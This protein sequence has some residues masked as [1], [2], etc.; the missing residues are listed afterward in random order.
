MRVSVVIPPRD[1]AETLA[2]L[3]SLLAQRHAAWEAIVVD[4]GS[5]ARSAEI[6]PEYAAKDERIRT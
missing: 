5:T 6:A 1:A 2:T 3:D 4:D